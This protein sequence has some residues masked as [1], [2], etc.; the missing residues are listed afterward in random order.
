MLFRHQLVTTFGIGLL[1]RALFE[2]LGEWLIIEECPRIVE[3]VVP[4]GLKIGH[5]RQDI[6]QLA[7]SDEGE[8]RRIDAI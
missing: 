7:V 2:L 3:L 8:Q 1:R 6:L 4:G 5:A